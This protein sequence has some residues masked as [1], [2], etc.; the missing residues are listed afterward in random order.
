MS[1]KTDLYWQ[2][3]E[4]VAECIKNDDYL[5]IDVLSDKSVELIKSFTRD[6]M[7]TFDLLKK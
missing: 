6:E 3:Q 5:Q 7:L 2:L 4:Q 1:S